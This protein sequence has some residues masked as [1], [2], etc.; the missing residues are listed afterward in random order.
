MKKILVGFLFGIGFV[1]GVARSLGI[2]DVISAISGTKTVGVLPQLSG[3]KP[4]NAELVLAALGSN[5]ASLFSQKTFTDSMET[6][7]GFFTWLTPLVQLD[8]SA[9]KLT[10]RTP[11]FNYTNFTELNLL[12]APLQAF[13]QVQ[14]AAN[15]QLTAAN[16]MAFNQAFVNFQAT[17]KAKAP[18]GFEKIPVTKPSVA[19]RALY[20]LHIPLYQKNFLATQ[21]SLT[22]A[23][24]AR[25][26]LAAVSNLFASMCSSTSSLITTT[27]LD[28]Q[29]LRFATD[30]TNVTFLTNK[31]TGLLSS[32]QSFLDKLTKNVTTT[33]S[34]SMFSGLSTVAYFDQGNFATLKGLLLVLQHFFTEKMCL[35]RAKTQAMFQQFFA[36]Y[37]GA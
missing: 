26:V 19:Q 33:K 5:F 34:T 29:S 2:T 20:S 16:Q 10:S 28:F 8:P 11:F 24:N 30:N 14:L 32:V 27:R 21:A 23:T 35:D 9:G 31:T 12:L 7:Q 36:K 18:V 3:Q 1:G 37:P 17:I 22:T 6:L 4:T 15:N 13:M 25:D